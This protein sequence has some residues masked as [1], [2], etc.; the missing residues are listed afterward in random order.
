MS[1]SM[2]KGK[3]K[4]VFFSGGLVDITEENNGYYV[5]LIHKMLSNIFEFCLQIIKRLLH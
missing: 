1:V 5:M 2:H 3:K 4:A